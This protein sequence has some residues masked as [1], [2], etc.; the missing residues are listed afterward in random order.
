MCT[1]TSTLRH[2]DPS[3]AILPTTAVG[4][5]TF[6]TACRSLAVLLDMASDMGCSFFFHQIQCLFA[7]ILLKRLRIEGLA[8]LRISVLDQLRWLIKRHPLIT[9]LPLWAALSCPRQRVPQ[10]GSFKPCFSSCGTLCLVDSNTLAFHGACAYHHRRVFQNHEAG[11]G[12][13]TLCHYSP[14]IA[15]LAIRVQ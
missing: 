3:Y 1:C 12:E 10:G 15:G 9:K 8:Q 2:S 4:S 5:T 7:A 13:A 6:S 11:L 14:L